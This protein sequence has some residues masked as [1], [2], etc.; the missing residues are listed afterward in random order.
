MAEGEDTARADA[1]VASPPQSPAARWQVP[2]HVWFG[3]AGLVLAMIL[4]FALD[5]SLP[6]GFNAAYLYSIAVIG[7]GLWRKRWIVIAAASLGIVLAGLAY[8]FKQESSESIPSSLVL[9]NRIGSAVVIGLTALMVVVFIGRGERLMTLARELAEAAEEREAS[10]QLVTAVK[11]IVDIGMWTYDYAHPEIV[12]WSDEVALIHGRPPGT[13]PSPAEAFEHYAPDDRRRLAEAIELAAA[14]GDPFMEEARLEMPDGTSKVILVL[15]KVILDAEGGRQRINGVVQDVTLWRDA[16]SA[17]SAQRRQ[18][19]QLVSAMPFIIWTANAD[20]VVDFLNEA[21]V[22]YTGVPLEGLVGEG[23]ARRVHPD[24][25][26]RVWADWGEAIQRRKNYDTEFRLQN[27]AGEFRWHRVSAQPEFAADGSVLRWWGCAIDIHAVHVLR[28]KADEVARERDMVLESI[29]DGVYTVDREWRFRY[30]NPAAETMLQRSAED[31]IG[32]VVWDEFP[33]EVGTEFYRVFHRA[34]ENHTVEFITMH[35]PT[36]GR[37]FDVVMSPS[38]GG[39][40]VFFRDT[41]ELRRLHEQLAHAQRLE[42]IGRLTGGIAHDFNNLLTVVIGGAEAIAADAALT[43]DAREMAELVLEASLRGAELTRRLLAFARRQPLEPRPVDVGSQLMSILP[44]IKRTLGE[45]VTVET[46]L[47]PDLPLVTID[48]GQLENALLNLAINA[49]DAMPDGGVI[50]LAAEKAVIDEDHAATF[51][52]VFP[53]TYVVVS[54]TDTGTGIDADLIP[55]LFDPF[56]TTKRL[57]EGSGLGLPMVWGFAKQSGGHVTV[58]SEVGKGSTFRL[59]LP[60]AASDATAAGD[61]DD[62]P[63]LMTARSGTILLV[64]DD[65]LVQRFAMEHLKATGF[66]VVAASSGPAALAALEAMDHVDLLFT[67]VIMPGGMSGKD[68]AEAVLAARPGTPVLYTSGYTEN[69]ILHNGRIDDDVSLLQ[70]PYTGAQLVRRVT[71][72]LASA[73]EV[74]DD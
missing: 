23:W 33:A 52:D 15:G 39:L 5:T 66:Q 68:L 45:A 44:I 48:P 69:V 34:M 40:T 65:P 63:A 7:A 28:Q 55:R 64:E 58:S 51:G 9:Y 36:L 42:S 50:T 54:V 29:A 2:L 53:G 56:F 60:L 41:T 27:W 17:L 35:S 25:I 20:G 49:R 4:V 62:Q 61:A 6:I 26:E 10:E 57:G 74:G 67:D 37:E 14:T 59:Y 71:E 16:E 1:Q 18:Y 73:R 43:D 21:M 22:R 13:K 3:V 46:S 24:D 70:K 11:R 12:D 38:D 47:Q 19:V 72:V 32:K 8:F 30:L 31:L